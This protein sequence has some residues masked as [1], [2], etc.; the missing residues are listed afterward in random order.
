VSALV[1][2]DGDPSGPGNLPRRAVPGMARLTAAMQQ[3]NRHTA[4]A[5]LIA[6]KSVAV[7]ADE[8]LG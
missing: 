6:D 8:C 5:I 1:D 3:Q 4:G 2:C 7:G